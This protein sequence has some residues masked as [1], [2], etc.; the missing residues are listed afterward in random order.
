MKPT[1]RDVSRPANVVGRMEEDCD[2]VLDA[3]SYDLGDVMVSNP[4]ANGFA[5]EVDL[6]R[7]WR[8]KRKYRDIDGYL[9]GL[10]RR[11]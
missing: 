4:D 7:Y 9:S 3:V 1:M 2:P 10:G 6:D 5:R 8:N 11:Y